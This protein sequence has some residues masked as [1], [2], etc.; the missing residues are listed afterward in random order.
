MYCAKCGNEIA[1]GSLFCN[2]CGTPVNTSNSIPNPVQANADSSNNKTILLALIGA[3][4]VFFSFSG[5]L[6]TFHFTYDYSVLSLAQEAFH[7]HS[8]SIWAIGAYLAFLS[9]ITCCI[10]TFSYF[11]KWIN[12]RT[13]KEIIT[14]AKLTS[15][16]TIV[17][18]NVTNISEIPHTI[19]VLDMHFH[20]FSYPTT[21]G[22]IIDIAAIVN[23]FIV[24]KAYE[25]IIEE[26]QK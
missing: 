14:L 6:I 15:V 24:T 5:I 3:F 18:L 9:W 26:E 19:K 2:K 21:L 20:L 4:L 13:G 17:S 8:F 22:I 16:I 1:D 7:Y 12:R 25:K 11:L 23:I 10:L